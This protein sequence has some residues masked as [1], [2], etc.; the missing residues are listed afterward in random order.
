MTHFLVRLPPTKHTHTKDIKYLLVHKYAI[1]KD[2]F[3]LFDRNMYTQTQIEKKIC[4]LKFIS[5]F[6]CSN[7]IINP[8][9]PCFKVF[10][11][12]TAILKNQK[13]NH[14][15]KLTKT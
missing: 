13:N 12:D 3:F 7:F 15:S 4:Y 8:R 9:H 11:C 1:H 5:Q 10:L 14:T 2:S 6:A